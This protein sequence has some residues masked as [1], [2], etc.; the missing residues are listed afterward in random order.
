MTSG[1]PAGDE[2]GGDSLVVGRGP[3]S[4]SDTPMGLKDLRSLC[5][6]ACGSTDDPLDTRR[7]RLCR[8]CRALAERLDTKAIGV[9][10]I[11][12]LRDLR[13]KD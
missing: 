2:F 9:T 7:T 6:A 4:N 1:V 12:M 13:K 5:C 11:A 10:L 8:R 3:S